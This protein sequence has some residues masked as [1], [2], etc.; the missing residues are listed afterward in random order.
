MTLL[1]FFNVGQN[2]AESEED[3]DEDE[4]SSDL[5]PSTRILVR[6]CLRNAMQAFGMV[7]TITTI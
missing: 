2:E 3:E 5:M 6:R 7:T 1:C 4:E